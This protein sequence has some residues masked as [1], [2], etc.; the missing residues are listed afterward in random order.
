L[1]CGREKGITPTS[2]KLRKPRHG[3]SCAYHNCIDAGEFSALV[4][5]VGRFADDHDDKL[6]LEFFGGKGRIAPAAE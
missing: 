5:A 4:T 1:I 3:P 6:D 2:P